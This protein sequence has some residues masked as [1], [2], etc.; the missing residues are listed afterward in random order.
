VTRPAQDASR[1]GWAE[2]EYVRLLT[3]ELGAAAH[4]TI[5]RPATL[6][7]NGPD[8]LWLEPRV[9]ADLVLRARD[10]DAARANAGVEPFGLH[11]R[12]LEYVEVCRNDE[13][14]RLKHARL[15]LTELGVTSPVAPP[16]QSASV[17]TP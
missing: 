7:A 11:H 10:V 2:A 4:G 5:G 16:T 3:A 13:L 6:D 1:L 8:I 14:V 17:H 9:W 15:W 12:L